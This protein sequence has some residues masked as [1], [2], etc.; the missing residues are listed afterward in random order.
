MHLNAYKVS[1]NGTK[2]RRNHMALNGRS[3]VAKRIAIH[4]YLFWIFISIA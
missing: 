3:M 1:L 2:E 4:M